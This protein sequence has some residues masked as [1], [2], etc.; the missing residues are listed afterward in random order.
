MYNGLIA[1]W[2]ESGMTSHDVVFQLRKIFAMKKIGH[3]GTL[4]PDVE[5][6]LLVCLGQGTKL[7][8]Y[9]MDGRKL[10]QGEVTLGIATD[11]QDASGQVIDQKPIQVAI[12]D[13]QIDRVLSGFNGWIDQEA[14][15]YSAVKVNGKKLYEYARAGIEVDPPIRSVWVDYFKRT[16]PSIYNPNQRTQC[17]NF[18]VS[19]GKGTYVRTL[20]VDAG[21]K[22]AYPAHMSKLER[23]ATGGFNKDQ[24]WSLDQLRVLKEEGRLDQAVIPLEV[25]VANLPRYDLSSEQAQKVQ[26]GVLLEK[27]YFD[28]LPDP[29]LAL[30]EEDR[31]LAIYQVHP[32]KTDYLK[33]YKMFP[34]EE[35]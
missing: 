22:L 35:G 21:K 32:K 16:G 29:Y 2:K 5:G 8:D 34:K 10:Y 18:E 28:I 15:L 24:S 20:A 19:C 12:G 11:T 14:P 7:V 26:N 30:F 6:V 3:T 9:L 27:D 23:L 33:P 25:A 4:D 1:I 31:L 17:F 13:S